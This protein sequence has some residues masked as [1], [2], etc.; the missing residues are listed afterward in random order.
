M[1]GAGRSGLAFGGYIGLGFLLFLLSSVLIAGPTG[2]LLALALWL[3]AIG[4]TLEWFVVVVPQQTS[5]VL[6]N[7]LDGTMREVLPGFA[8]KLAWEHAPIEHFLELRTLTVALDGDF[9]AKDGPVVRLKGTVQ[10][11]IKPGQAVTVLAHTEDA[12]FH[13]IGQQC[14]SFLSDY[15]AVRPAKDVRNQGRDLERS[16]SDIYAKDLSPLSGDSAPSPPSFRSPTS[17][18]K[19]ST[20][21]FARNPRWRMNSRTSLAGCAAAP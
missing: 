2:Y 17:R 18:S 14:A 12:F 5:L 9:I 19:R 6:V 20:R 8:F 4:A 3:G 11:H 7:R 13:G 1:N 15:V 16:Y 10:L 21:R